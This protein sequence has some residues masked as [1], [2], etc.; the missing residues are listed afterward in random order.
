MNRV[1]MISV[2]SKK[3]SQEI[4]LLLATGETQIIP[5]GYVSA[6]FEQ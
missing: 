1:K 4:M 5:C 6:Q 2:C 3:E